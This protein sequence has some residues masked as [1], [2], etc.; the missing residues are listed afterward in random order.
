M[1]RYIDTYNAYYIRFKIAWS[2]FYALMTKINNQCL[3]IFLIFNGLG[4]SNTVY[5]KYWTLKYQNIFFPI[6][7]FNIFTF[8]MMWR[9][10]Y[11]QGTRRNSIELLKNIITPIVYTEKQSL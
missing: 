5:N 1:A 9:N 8:N 3:N 6:F 2:W 4:V 11:V 7:V 10:S